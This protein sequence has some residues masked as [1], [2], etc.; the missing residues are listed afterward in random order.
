MNRAMKRTFAFLVMAFVAVA[1]CFALDGNVTWYWFE[2]DYNVEYYRYQLDGE[3]DGFWTVVDW[4]VTEVTLTVDV[5][6]VHTLY[7]Q[8]SY[9]GENWSE[10]SFIDSEV[11]VEEEPVEE[12]P[13]EEPEEFFVEEE[14]EFDDFGDSFVAIGPTTVYEADLI[15]DEV[16]E[17]KNRGA[18]YL[19]YGV[20]YLNSLPNSAGPKSLGAFVSYSQTFANLGLGDFGIK[21]N[22]ALY[23]NKNLVFNLSQTQ[24]MSYVNALALYTVKI[25]NCDFFGGIGP[26]FRFTM[27]TD[28]KA[29]LGMAAEAG[30]RF[31][32]SGAVVL[33]IVVS[34]HYYLVPN[35]DMANV[36]DVKIFRTLAF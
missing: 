36:F 6:E 34:D 30:I 16:S 12:L 32:R 15:A 9:D 13:M 18:L 1:F 21:T 3:F 26:D 7:L 11:F 31:Y 22:L 24:F 2:N 28:V 35:S 10:S 19:D 29:K 20:G 23:T 8:Q 33:G 4:S 27:F 25:G 17:N 5:T 14:L